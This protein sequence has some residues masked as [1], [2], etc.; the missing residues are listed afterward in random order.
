M[1]SCCS[2][3]N[4]EPPRRTARDS[5]SNRPSFEVEPPLVQEQ[6]LHG[7]VLVPS[8]SFLMGSDDEAAYPEDGE[9]PVVEVTT[10]AFH[11]DACAVSNADFSRF[12][13]ATGH[14]TEA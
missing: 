2:P 11:I 9:G 7:M 13:A 4:P 5:R 3:Q 6:G 12:A 10:S 8:G 14:V 1:T